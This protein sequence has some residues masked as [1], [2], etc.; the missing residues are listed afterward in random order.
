MLIPL[1][2]ILP[3]CA[4]DVNMYEVVTS[5]FHPCGSCIGDLIHESANRKFLGNFFV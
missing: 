4:V 1:S 3:I 5:I 2:L